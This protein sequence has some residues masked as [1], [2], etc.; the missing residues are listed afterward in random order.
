MKKTEWLG[1]ISFFLV[2]TAPVIYAVYTREFKDYIYISLF[3]GVFF[4][5]MVVTSSK[6]RDRKDCDTKEEYED[7]LARY[8][9]AK[10]LAIPMIPI[11]GIFY[12]SILISVI[13]IFKYLYTLSSSNLRIVLPATLAITIGYILFFF[14]QNFR[15]AYGLSE[16]IV[17]V[18]AG[19]LHTNNVIQ[20][21]EPKFY[22]VLLSASI[23]LIVRG[24]DNMSIGM[25]NKSGSSL[26]NKILGHKRWRD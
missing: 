8:Y 13:D 15:A 18:L 6:P 19:I 1:V 20:F 16:I 7:D 17:G 22:L 5:F 26:L 10:F 4:S 14:R 11:G 25:K 12:Y 3:I 9:Q 24:F 2:C 21:D 23:Y